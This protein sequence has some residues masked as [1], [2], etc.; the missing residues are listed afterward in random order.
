MS[1]WINDATGQKLSFKAPATKV[2]GDE[3]VAQFP[4]VDSQVS[5]ISENKASA[6][7]AATETILTL[8]TDDLSAACTLTL[9][10][11]LPVGAK[12]YVKFKCGGTKYDVTVKI[13][14]DT[15]ATITGV[16]N[17]TNIAAFLWDGTHLL[18]I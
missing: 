11:H 17:K 8:G 15:E 4:F 10:Q 7:I 14:E 1:T 13:G 9:E 18:S 16:A 3:V 12:M 5:I 2:G 6:T